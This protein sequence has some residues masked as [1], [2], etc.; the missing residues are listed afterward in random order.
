MMSDPYAPQRREAPAMAYEGLQEKMFRK[1]PPRV[2]V[3]D[4]RPIMHM[5]QVLPNGE[6]GGRPRPAPE[7]LMAPIA[8]TKMLAVNYLTAK[9]ERTRQ[10]R[11]IGAGRFLDKQ[12]ISLLQLDQPTS[13]DAAN[14]MRYRPGAYGKPAPPVPWEGGQ[15]H[16]RDRDINFPLR[17][18]RPMMPIATMRQRWQLTPFA[19]SPGT[20]ATHGNPTR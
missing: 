5:I 20:S 13:L 17:T 18:D 19:Q 10:E 9:R 8:G 2:T 12:P 7:P 4:A 11:I 14:R 3:G 1:Y 6:I 16:E 15:R